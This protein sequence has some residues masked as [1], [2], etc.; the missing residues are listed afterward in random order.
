MRY[1]IT[2]EDGHHFLAEDYTN[3][4]YDAMCDGLITIIRLDDGKILNEDWVFMSL[5]NWDVEEAK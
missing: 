3:D 1:L 5:P 4:D 2:D